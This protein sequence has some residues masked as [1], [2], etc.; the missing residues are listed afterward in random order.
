MGSP[1]LRYA[2][3]VGGNDETL[4]TKEHE[5]LQHQLELLGYTLIYIEIDWRNTTISRWVQQV[6]SE[7]RKHA[8]GTF[9]L[10]GF[11][12]GAM[13]M[14]IAASILCAEHHD[15]AVVV[16]ASLSGYFA[17][18]L[19]QRFAEGYLTDRPAELLADLARYPFAKVKIPER[20]P[21]ALIAGEEDHH[22]VIESV[23]RA[24]ATFR[25]AMDES[26]PGAHHSI[27][28]M[29][30]AQTVAWYADELAR[31]S[32][33]VFTDPTGG[34]GEVEIR[35]TEDGYDFR[36]TENR[37]AVRHLSPHGWRMFRDALEADP[38]ATVIRIHHHPLEEGR[39]TG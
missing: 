14:A 25:H 18:D 21:I 33:K 9:A 36:T 39:E 30:F 2:L 8:P 4:S 15:P 35:R 20:V 10:V 22:T 37:A 24:R 11:S 17:E 32:W 38:D 26:V 3:Y 31:L 12:F 19:D 7:A 6:L 16:L 1:S 13:T 5:K 29:M 27:D 23:A 28:I 34:G